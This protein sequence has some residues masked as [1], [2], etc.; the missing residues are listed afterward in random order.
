MHLL[1]PFVLLAALVHVYPVTGHTPKFRRTGQRHSRPHTLHPTIHPSLDRADTANLKTSDGLSLHYHDPHASFPSIRSFAS[2]HVSQF[3][4]PVVV[5]EH[6]AH[7]SGTT[8]DAD[9]STITIAFK[10]RD[11]WKLAYNDWKEHPTVLL[12][13]FADSCGLGRDSSERSLHLGRN[14]TT[15]WT[16]MQITFEMVEVPLHDAIHPEYDVEVVIDTFDVH[17]P[18]PPMGL[19]HIRRHN[20]TQSR[21]VGDD[22]ST[23]AAESGNGND[24]TAME[25]SQSNDTA[26]PDMSSGNI[27]DSASSYNGADPNTDRNGTTNTPSPFDANGDLDYDSLDTYYDTWYEPDLEKEDPNEFVDLWDLETFD[28]DEDEYVVEDPSLLPAGFDP[29]RSAGSEGA[30]R[31]AE[32]KLSWNPFAMLRNCV[33]LPILKAVL[34]TA[35]YNVI[36]G[37]VSFDISV[38]FKFFKK[39]ATIVAVILSEKGYTPSGEVTFDT[40]ASFPMQNTDDFGYAYLLAESGQIEYTPKGSSKTV[41]GNLTAYCVGCR[42]D[43]VNIS[44]SV[45]DFLKYRSKFRFSLARGFAN[46]EV[47]LV[48]GRLDFSA[49][50]GVLFDL[51]YSGTLVEQGVARIPLSPLIIPGIIIVGPFAAVNIGLEY[52]IGAQGKFLARNNIGWSNMKAKLDMLNGANSFLGEWTPTKPVPVVSLELEGYAKLGPFVTAGLEFGVDILSGKLAISAAIETK[53][54]LPVGISAA[55]TTGNTVETQFQ[56]CQGFNV[57][58]EIKAEIYVL[59]QSGTVKKHY[60]NKEIPFP[61]IFSKCIELPVAKKIDALVPDQPLPVLPPFHEDQVYRFITAN[62]P[63]GTLQVIWMPLPNEYIYAVQPFA[64]YNSQYV[65]NRL[66]QG[67]K[68]VSTTNATAGT[69]DNRVFYVIPFELHYARGTTPLRI[70][71]ANEVPRGAEVLYVYYLITL[72][73]DRCAPNL[74]QNNQQTLKTQTQDSQK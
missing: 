36:N 50:V 18:R 59:L 27:Q 61:T 33:L 3:L 1:R 63:N 53:V 11:A 17:D 9:T 32:C 35:I 45:Q 13:A 7:I 24:G 34:P 42:A 25:P 43:G 2:V 8:C 51:E 12:V 10:N 28:P 30:G 38:F 49:G 37:L 69:Y 73:G 58:L 55:I 62:F 16:K 68:L 6:S 46:A 22:P 39:A 40:N 48:D 74:Y 56:D 15:S 52:E 65:V 19:S 21:G 23:P 66:F 26:A 41:T 31:R 44:L 71:P 29:L 60:L 72:A 54:S 14:M 67:S 64:D 5:L 57:A 70:A 20:A 4:H 47:E